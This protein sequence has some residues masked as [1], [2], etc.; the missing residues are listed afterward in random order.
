MNGKGWSLILVMEYCV[1][2]LHGSEHFVSG[3]KSK[4]PSG[5]K[6]LFKHVKSSEKHQ[7]D[8]QMA[9]F[10]CCVPVLP[11]GGKGTRIKETE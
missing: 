2:N 9:K 6:L 4:Q 5:N 1:V 8:A 10:E 11:T 7:L 3:A